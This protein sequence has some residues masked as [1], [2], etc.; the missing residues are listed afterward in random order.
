VSILIARISSDHAVHELVREDGVY[1][2]R[3]FVEQPSCEREL[4]LR[5]AGEWL[6]DARRCG[7]ESFVRIG[8]SLKIP[9]RDAATT[10]GTR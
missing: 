6:D 1:L 8:A 10:E 3:T 2:L 7:G 9:P 5:E 4:T